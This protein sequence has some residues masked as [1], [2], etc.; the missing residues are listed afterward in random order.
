MNTAAESNG[1]VLAEIINGVVAVGVE[2]EQR[3]AVASERN[4]IV[5]RAGIDCHV[6]RGVEDAI[7][8]VVGIDD[9]VGSGVIDGGG[10]EVLPRDF[11]F[12]VDDVEE[13]ALGIFDDD[14]TVADVEDHVRAAD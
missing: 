7:I 10:T 1:V 13:F 3:G 2:G 14:R 6:P 12:V 5:A 8:K 4:I 9:G 11:I